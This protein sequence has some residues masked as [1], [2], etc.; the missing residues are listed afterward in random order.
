MK[1]GKEEIMGL[2]AAVERYLKVD[3]GAERRLLDQRADRVVKALGGLPGIQCEIDVPE[4][5]NRVPHVVVRWDEAARKL[6]SQ[7]AVEQ[8][9]E[10]EPPISVS[11]AGQGG[12]RIS[13][14]MLRGDEHRIVA[15]RLREIL[16]AS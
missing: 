11:R 14:W 12:L 8:L 13:M 15:R 9:I 7:Q 2:V 4:I 5:A 1:V 6:T 10:G 16:Q 3:H